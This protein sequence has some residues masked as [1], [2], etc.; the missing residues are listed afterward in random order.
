MPVNIG[1]NYVHIR[2]EARSHVNIGFN[3]VHIR[4]E[5][6]RIVEQE[7]LVCCRHI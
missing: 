7:Q 6:R 1:F 3:Y 4:L 2:L 5:A